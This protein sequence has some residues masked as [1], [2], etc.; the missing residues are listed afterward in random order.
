MTATDKAKAYDKVASERDVCRGLLF[1]LLDKLRSLTY[2]G[3]DSAF[4]RKGQEIKTFGKSLDEIYEDLLHA[5][6]RIANDLA[7][8]IRILIET[9]TRLEELGLPA[10]IG[11]VADKVLD[12]GKAKEHLDR[13]DLD[14]ETQKERYSMTD[15][16]LCHALITFYWEYRFGHDYPG[17]EIEIYRSAFLH[18][19]LSIMSRCNVRGTK[20]GMVSF[21]SEY[22]AKKE[23]ERD[24]DC[25]KQ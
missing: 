21:I 9:G 13:F 19:M 8:L 20:D 11:V 18:I 10:E 25:R 4:H 6:E 23:R 3:M 2:N 14:L 16:D 7:G 15:E 24:Q 22:R 17:D 1:E 12:L 5:D